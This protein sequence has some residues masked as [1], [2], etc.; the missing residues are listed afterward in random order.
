MCVRVCAPV[1]VEKLK[2][3]KKED[4]KKVSVH[5]YAMSVT[6]HTRVGAI[7]HHMK[8]QWDWHWFKL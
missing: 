7:R 8:Q 1:F 5:L 4:P 6:L 3:K 2:W